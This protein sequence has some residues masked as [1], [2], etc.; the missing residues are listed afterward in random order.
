MIT[1]YKCLMR[2][3]YQR[4]LIKKFTIFFHLRMN[5]KILKNYYNKIQQDSFIIKNRRFN[6]FFNHD[7]DFDEYKKFI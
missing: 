3:F 6:I 1:H 7:L 5:L 2:L 4:N